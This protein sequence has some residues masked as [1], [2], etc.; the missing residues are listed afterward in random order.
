MPLIKLL[1][2]DS[3]E[4]AVTFEYKFSE[5]TH[6][7]TVIF[8]EKCELSLNNKTKCETFFTATGTPTVM[9]DKPIDKRNAELNRQF[10]KGEVITGKIKY[11]GTID[12]TFPF[13]VILSTL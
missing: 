9:V 6:V 11:I 12:L 4:N 8:S 5:D 10:S 2:I 13:Y 7:K 3:S 1:Q